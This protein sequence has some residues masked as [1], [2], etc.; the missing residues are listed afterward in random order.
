MIN[1]NTDNTLKEKYDS[2]KDKYLGWHRMNGDILPLMNPEYLTKNNL[3][4]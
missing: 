3:W 2:D 1:D 4:R